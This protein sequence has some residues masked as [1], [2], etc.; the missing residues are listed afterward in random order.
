MI[1]SDDAG[2]KAEDLEYAQWQRRRAAI[3]RENEALL[4]GFE[5]WLAGKGLGKKTI[6]D[7][8]LNV[9]FFISNYLVYYEELH[10]AA[11]G[12]SM[13]DEFLDYWFRARRSGRSHPRLKAW[14]P[15]SKNFTCL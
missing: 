4:T 6:R 1:Q 13:L 8:R 10:S 15:A 3:L 2:K 11:A 9:E 5:A 7:H 14:R 12:V